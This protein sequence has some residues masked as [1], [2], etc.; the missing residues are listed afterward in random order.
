[1]RARI[2]IKNPPGEG[3]HGLHNVR[4]R[5]GPFLASQPEFVHGWWLQ[6][7]ERLP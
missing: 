6:H 2:A 5:V 4:E 3:E 1:M 7:G